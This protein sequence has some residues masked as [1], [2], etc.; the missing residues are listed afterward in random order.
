MRFL[1][2]DINRD[3]AAQRR[4]LAPDAAAFGAAGREAILAANGET[5]P[6][7]EKTAYTV[8]YPITVDTTNS[9]IALLPPAC[10]PLSF[11]NCI[12]SNMFVWI[13][14]LMHDQTKTSGA[15]CES[16]AEYRNV[17]IVSCFD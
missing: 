12:Y 7:A 2:A 9:T 3:Y 8:P 13:L 5:L 15:I 10:T 11:P 1:H 4:Y 17:I 16:R 14:L 6:E